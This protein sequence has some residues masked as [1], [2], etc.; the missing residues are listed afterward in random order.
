MKTVKLL[1][2]RAALLQL[3]RLIQ[4]HALSFLLWGLNTKPQVPS[5][6]GGLPYFILVIYIL[7]TGQ[8]MTSCDRGGSSVWETSILHT[9]D[10]L[11]N[12]L[13]PWGGAAAWSHWAEEGKRVKG[14]CGEMSMPGKGYNGDTLPGS[15]G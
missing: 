7:R 8:E 2:R 1:L 10:I 5:L 13:C 9:P 11:V 12:I 4:T 15:V 6:H 14:L 3:P